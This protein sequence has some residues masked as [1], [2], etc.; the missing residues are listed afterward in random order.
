MTVVQHPWLPHDVPYAVYFGMA[1]LPMAAFVAASMLGEVLTAQEFEFGTIVEY[2]LAPAP[3]ALK[4]GARL[5]RLVLSA[6]VGAA[7]MLVAIGIVTGVWPDALW[8]VTL[9]LLPVAGPDKNKEN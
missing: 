2:R 4:L 8:L 5:T 9:I 3:A 6:F 1:L 7:T